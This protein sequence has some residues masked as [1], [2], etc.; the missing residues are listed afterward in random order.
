MS[1]IEQQFGQQDCQLLERETSYDGFFKVDRIKL[2]HRLYSGEWSEVMQRELFIRANA[3]CVLPYDPVEGTVVLVEQFRAPLIGVKQSPWLFELVAGMNE[4]GEE[5]LEVAH[6]EAKEEADLELLN[7][8]PIMDYWPSP[9]GSTEKVFLYCARVNSKG[10]GGIH[11]LASEHEDIRVHVCSVESAL[12][13]MQV[14]QIN[15]AAAIIALQW[16]AL[17]RNRLDEMWCVA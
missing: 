9:G 6:R 17:N 8:E 3:T 1:H 12:Q 4:P 2:R 7:L 10:A 14:G 11:G 13:M 16:L 15:N 5:P